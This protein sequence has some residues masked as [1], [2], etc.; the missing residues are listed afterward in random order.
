M[1]QLEFVFHK[2]KSLKV[3]HAI[4]FKTSPMFKKKH[5]TNY[6]MKRYFRL[7][8]VTLR[9]VYHDFNY[10]KNY[11]Y[12]LHLSLYQ[13]SHIYGQQMQIKEYFPY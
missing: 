12:D 1:G 11:I 5:T 2:M 7:P 8:E 3:F 13:E 10:I 6:K 4:V 9:S